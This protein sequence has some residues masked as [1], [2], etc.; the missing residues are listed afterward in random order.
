MPHKN[1]KKILACYGIA[2]LLSATVFTTGCS[3]QEETDEKQEDQKTSQQQPVSV[4]KDRENP[5]KPD[6]SEVQIRGK[7]G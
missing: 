3:K 5:T 7:S 6:G 2:G 4:D 1:L